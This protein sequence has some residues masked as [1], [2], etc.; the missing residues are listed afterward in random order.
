MEETPVINVGQVEHAFYQAGIQHGRG[1]SLGESAAQLRKAAKHYTD[2][3]EGDVAK[4]IADTLANLASQFEAQAV[5]QKKESGKLL[6]RALKI[7]KLK[8]PSL[9]QRY[10][11]AIMGLVEGWEK[12]G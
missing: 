9:R 8:Y 10:K 2:N 6:N 3:G 4:A 1:Y 5:L 12:R 7:G 11:N